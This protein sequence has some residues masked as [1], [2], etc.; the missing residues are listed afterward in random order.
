MDC[1]FL[2]RIVENENN[3][4]KA[5]IYTGG[6]HTIVYIWFLIKFND[7]KITDYYYMNTDKLFGTKKKSTSKNN[8]IFNLENKIR[9]SDGYN[10]IYDIYFPKKF[11]QCIKIKKI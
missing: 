1:F 2:R 3:I 9:K 4:K 10:D 5:I 11:S 6:F 8:F 7:F